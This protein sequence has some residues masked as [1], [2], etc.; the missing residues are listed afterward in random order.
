MDDQGVTLLTQQKAA[1][2]LNMNVRTF[3]REVKAGRIPVVPYGRT[4]RYN[5]RDLI[6]WANSARPLSDYLGDQT[7]RS[8]MHISR[9][10]LMDTEL[11]FVSLL[12]ART[13]A[14]RQIGPQSELRR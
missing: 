11:S 10:Q 7:R 6:R 13:N 8:G 4:F 5:V 14:K 12:D 1:R 9:S 3:V 2:F